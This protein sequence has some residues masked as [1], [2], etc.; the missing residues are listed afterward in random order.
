MLRWLELAPLLA[1]LFLAAIQDWRYRR[2][3]NYLTLP[4]LAAGIARSFLHGTIGIEACWLGIGLGFAIT[5]PLFAMR[6]IGGG[7][8]KLLIALGAWLGPAMTLEIFAIAAVIGMIVVLTQAL[9]QRRMATLLRNTT[10]LTLSLIQAD[11]V[12]IDNIVDMGTS[13]HSVNKPLPY[14][15]IILPALL[16]AL[17]Y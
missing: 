1:V 7:D 4:L 3:A 15:V 8:V 2:I 13:A 17:S 14:A 11:Q 16:L 6:A 5:F 10:V 9:V 12:G